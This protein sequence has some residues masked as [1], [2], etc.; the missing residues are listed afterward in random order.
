MRET[1]EQ[2]A[3]KIAAYL[4]RELGDC[5]HGDASKCRRMSQDDQMCE[6]CIRNFLLRKAKKE[7]NENKEANK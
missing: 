3:V 7:L 1:K 4:I 5:T 6:K 2:R